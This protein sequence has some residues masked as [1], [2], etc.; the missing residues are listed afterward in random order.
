M[1]EAYAALIEAQL[2]AERAQRESINTRAASLLTTAISVST[3]AVAILAVFKGTGLLHASGVA[4]WAFLIGLGLLLVSAGFAMVAGRPIGITVV[5]PDSMY[6]M[7]QDRWADPQTDAL[8]NTAYANVVILESIRPGTRRKNL[9]YFSGTLCQIVAIIFFIISAVAEALA[10]QAG[11]G[12]A[13]I[14]QI[15]SVNNN[16]ATSVIPTVPGRG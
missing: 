11:D 14:Q 1:S 10:A 9:E 4:K 3:L 8:K 12:T 15:T 6:T 5:K 7:V 16:T 13:V 2:A